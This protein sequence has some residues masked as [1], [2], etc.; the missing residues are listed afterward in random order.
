MQVKLKLPTQTII[1]EAGADGLCDVDALTFAEADGIT[2]V[3]GR[4]RDISSMLDELENF[5]DLDTVLVE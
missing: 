2:T 5:C 3:S 4:T 1:D